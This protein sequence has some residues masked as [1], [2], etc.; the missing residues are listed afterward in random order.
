[1]KSV[2]KAY[3][4]LFFVFFLGM[5]ILG[6]PSLDFAAAQNI[7]ATEQS[8]RDEPHAFSQKSLNQKET[9]A[10]NAPRLR[11]LPVGL[12]RISI[13]KIQ[14]R[15]VDLAFKWR[16][17][18]RVRKLFQCLPVGEMTLNDLT[19]LETAMKEQCRE[20][21]IDLYIPQQLF[22]FSILYVVVRNAND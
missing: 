21:P 14:V 11:T 16:M 6:M 19:L 4:A 8:Y 22:N 12:D 9:I 18:R 13:K 1:M 3:N 2:R 5:F 15:F 7:G 17:K 10:R 20:Y